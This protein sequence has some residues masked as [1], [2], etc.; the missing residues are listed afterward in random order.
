MK[1]TIKNIIA[2]AII[3][4]L[5]MLLSCSPK[6]NKKMD[7]WVG[8]H[9]TQLYKQWGEPVLDQERLIVYTI[10]STDPNDTEFFIMYYFFLTEKGNVQ[11]WHIVYKKKEA[12]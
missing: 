6:L 5:M 4:M 3:I 2:I 7:S 10:K 8:Q 11:K 1:T 12:V 9:R